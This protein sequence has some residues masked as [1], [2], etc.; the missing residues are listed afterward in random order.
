MRGRR[1]WAERLLVGAAEGVDVGAWAV[2]PTAFRVG[3]GVVG[4]GGQSAEAPPQP[5]QES[6]STRTSTRG[7]V[8]FG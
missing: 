8:R 5:C 4:S 6:S 7:L 3:S 2:L 1:H